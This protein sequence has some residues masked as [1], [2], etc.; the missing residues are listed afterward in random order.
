MGDD[1]LL[2]ESASRTQAIIGIKEDNKAQLDQ[3]I[4]LSLSATDQPIILDA[5][6]E[7][8]S[9][10]IPANDT[11]ILS[12]NPSALELREGGSATI[13]IGASATPIDVITASLTAPAGGSLSAE[14]LSPN[15][16]LRI[17]LSPQRPVT[18]IAIAAISDDAAEPLE[19]GALALRELS[20]FARPGAPLRISIPAND[21]PTV[22]ASLPELIMEGDAGILSI[23][24]QRPPAADSVI[25]IRAEGE[26]A[27]RV[28]INGAPMSDDILLTE[29][30]TRTQATIGVKEDNKA[31]LDQRISLSLSATDQPIILDADSE[32][33]SFIVPAS[34]TPQITF[35][36]A[37]VSVVETDGSDNSRAV[38]IMSRPSPATDV[39]VT[40][41]VAS[42]PTLSANDYTL[43][44]RLVLRAGEP[45]TD[46]VVIVK[47]DEDR[48]DEE[49][50][51]IILDLE[52]PEAFASIGSPN[53]LTLTVPINDQP[54]TLSFRN[55]GSAIEEGQSRRVFI[56]STLAT[57]AT[58]VV[59]VVDEDDRGQLWIAVRNNRLRSTSD[60][61][62]LRVFAQAST[63]FYVGIID[64]ET[65]EYESTYRLILERVPGGSYGLENDVFT[66]TVPASDPPILSIAP[67]ALEL[68]EGSSATVAISASATPI[69]VIAASLT[70]PTGD[71]LSA[72]DLSPNLPIRIELSPQRPATEIAM[73][74]I[75]DNAAELFESGALAL[76]K[77]SGFA[78][79]AATLTLSVPAND[80]PTVTA[81]LPELIMEGDAGILS[82]EAQRS[83]A[84]TAAIRI[85]RRG[86]GRGA[87]SH[88]RRAHGRRHPSG[89]E[90]QPDAGH[91]W[92]K[93]DN[94]AQLDQRISLSLSAADQPII[95]DADSERLSFTVPA[96]DTPT[97]IISPDALELREGSSATII[98]SASVTPI[99]VITAS[100]TTPTGGSLSAEDLSPNPPIRIELSP[101]RPTTEIAIAAISD[102]IAELPE[103]GA[104]ALPELSGFVQ[105]GAPLRISIPANDTP[106]VTA[107]L[108]ELIM[109]GDAGILSIAAQRSP[110]ATA[111]IRIRAEGEGAAR[112]LINGSP[113]GN[114][115][116]LAESSSRT[117]AIIE[118]KEDNKAQ[119]LDQQIS[120]TLSAEGQPIILDADSGRLFFTVPPMTPPPSASPPML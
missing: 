80:T 74:V 30:A 52:D 105:S 41:S 97:L 38:A 62:T 90:R 8:L 106:T 1:I 10:T 101:Q 92:I 100:L 108:P 40:L 89:R 103:S 28:L 118:V 44:D 76:R 81:S 29:S 11:P 99:G 66:V 87:R 93:E 17:E 33:L 91:H 64:D 37:E 56:R 63:S 57:G 94:K 69:D 88:K 46:L 61:L 84:A 15:L 114:D 112:I 20:G 113:M 24:A 102:N 109:E 78:E 23:A 51:V 115:I 45:A 48:E 43:P 6:S 42:S 47:H 39:V 55:A 58:D 85:R 18:E 53:T 35:A 19:S 96:N 72:D 77:L 54:N 79:A 60:R 59:I 22:T 95:L 73:T 82:I 13:A 75:S 4:S 83:P 31:Q 86:G 107:S 2:A 116:L 25:R 7:R 36:R 50:A 34:D 32:R 9:F 27:A 119:Q 16:P 111:A 71:S 26:G 5:D 3:R 70:V 14:D 12:I 49:S 65:P 110:A 67:D 98:I 68:R 117:Q 120:L 21:T 104:L